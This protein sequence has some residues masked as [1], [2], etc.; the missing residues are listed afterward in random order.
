M[1]HW[2]I[3]LLA[4]IDCLCGVRRREVYR[5]EQHGKGGPWEW[6]FK[7]LEA[8]DRLARLLVRSP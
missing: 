4:I 8:K 2:R 6:H 1:K 5:W 7:G 3:M